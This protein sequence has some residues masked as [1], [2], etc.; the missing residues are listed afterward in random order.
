MADIEAM[1][2]QVKVVRQDQD[3]LRF[4]WWPG[5]N[6]EEDPA[7]YRMT[8]H[9]FGGTWSPSCCTYA[10]HRTA[11]DHAQESSSIA[12]DAVLRNFYVDDC[13][14]SVPTDEEAIQLTKQ[15]KR[16]VA[17]GGFNLTKWTSNSQGVREYIPLEDQSKKVKERVL[18]TPLEDR[19]LGV[20]WSVEEDE[21]GFKVQK[22]AKPLTKRGILSMLSSVYH[23]LGIAS[24]FVLGARKVMQELCRTKMGWDDKVP[25]VYQQQWQKWT[26]GL[27]EMARIRVPRCLQPVR[28]I[29][30][31]LHHFADASEMAYGVVSYLRIQGNDG[32]V[33]STLVMAK[34]RLAPLKKMTI[35]LL[36]L[37][38]ATLAI[39]QDALLRRE[40]GVDLARSQYW[41]DS[42]IVLQYISNTE[43][44]Y[45]TFVANRVAEI[46]DATRPEAWRHVP[47]QDNPADDASRGLSAQELA[48]SRWMHGPEFL[49][50]ALEKLP[51]LDA[52]DPEVKKPVVASFTVHAPVE[53]HPVEKLVASYSNWSRLL[54]ALAC[55]TMAADVCR[56]KIP[57]TTELRA[58]HVQKAEEALVVHVQARHYGQEIGALAK[59]GKLDSSSSL[60]QLRPVM[61]EGVLVVPGR[62]SNARLPEEAKAP[63]VLPSQHPAVESLV[64]HVHEKTAHSG[65]EYVLAELRRCYWV[66]GG[67]SLVKRVLA[68]CLQCKKRKARPCSQQE[69]DLP[70][71]RV[72]PGEP[73]FSSVGVDYFGPIPVKRGRGREKKYGCLFT[74]LATRAI[75]IEVADTLGADSFINCLQRFMA[76]R[77]EP[78][79]I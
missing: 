52:G 32:R 47:T 45:H 54:R 40:L 65:Q 35:P 12:K 70:P 72:T 2:H 77:G 61:K 38:A 26:Q 59:G 5:G 34:S 17:Q 79:L 24:L 19:A 46:Q 10:L 39:R 73:A 36:E 18:D 76:R 20:Y 11:E 56:K 53:E 33:V 37:Q 48:R 6:L 4:L 16:L 78:K 71:D 28:A 49:R 74:C 75:H 64:R 27:H 68:G 41:T 60:A 42:T 30:R 66:V 15:L 62:L 55:F 57:P 44:R 3:V 29:E 25:P 31:Q 50:L 67:S 21:L 63:A 13:L 51:P 22:M 1:F 43:A 23:P 7:R 14:K 9:L 8:V 69:A 58:E